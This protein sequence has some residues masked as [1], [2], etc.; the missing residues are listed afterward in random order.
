MQSKQLQN[1]IMVLQERKE[2]IEIENSF[3]C[4]RIKGKNDPAWIEMLL[5]EKLGLIRQN[6]VKVCINNYKSD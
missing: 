2:A 1:K 3:L 5:M 4:E 6:Q